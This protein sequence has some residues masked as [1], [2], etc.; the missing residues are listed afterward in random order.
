MEQGLRIRL[1]ISDRDVWERCVARSLGEDSEK[2]FM[3]HYKCPP[4]GTGCRKDIQ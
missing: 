2:I 4:E 3:F 1:E